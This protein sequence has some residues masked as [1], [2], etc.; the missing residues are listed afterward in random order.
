M[1]EFFEPLPAQAMSANTENKSEGQETPTDVDSHGDVDGNLGWR[2]HQVEALE[3]AGFEFRASDAW[4]RLDQDHAL[5]ASPEDRTSSAAGA[6]PPREG[7]RL[8]GRDSMKKMSRQ[9]EARGW[10]DFVTGSIL[11]NLTIS[12]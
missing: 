11:N 7:R 3:E 4:N 10:F 1:P 5:R 2:R 8:H 12:K 9:T 6:G